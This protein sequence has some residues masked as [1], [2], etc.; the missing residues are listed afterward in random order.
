MGPDNRTGLYVGGSWKL[1]PNLTLNL[2]LGYDRDTGRTDSDVPAIPEINAA[3]PGYG[4]AVKQ[5]NMNLAPQIGFA[6]DP[7]KNGKTVIRGGVGLFYENV[8]WNNV[9]FDRP[10]RLR[11]GAFNAVSNACLSGGPNPVPVDGG[12]ITPAAGI[13]G[14]H[15]G[16]V[17]P[18]DYVVLA[19]GF[20][21]QSF[22]SAKPESKFRWHLLEPGAWCAGPSS[23]RAEL[24]TTSFGRDQL[25]NPA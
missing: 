16:S 15:V 13:C 2:G 22:Q 17:I 4:N 10:E 14:N 8:I 12:T 25:R 21:R 1:K 24:S 9:R 3:F 6:W 19:T 20:G 18:A 7:R 11:S 23:V 5:A